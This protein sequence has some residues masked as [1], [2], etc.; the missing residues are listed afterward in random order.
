VEGEDFELN[1]E[2]RRVVELAR[3][4]RTP[5]DSDKRRV[6]AALAATLGGAALGVASS[7]AVASAAKSAGALVAMRALLAAALLTSAGVGTY[8]WTRAPRG[9]S[10]VAP[11]V[12]PPTAP[13]VVVEPLPPA[14]APP[15]EGDPLLAELTLLRQAQ[16]ALRDGDAKRAL[17]LAAR[18]AALY[19][20]SQMSVERGALRVFALCSLG[21]KSEARTLARE[22]IA[23]APSS[24]LRKSLE[25]SCGMR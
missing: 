19:P 3:A 6:R 12:A 7:T 25:E 16:R 14:A 24:P 9:P 10:V 13:S 11:A 23:E 5:G 1:G 17:E 2:E 8:F 22:L 18:H 20:R 15:A 21:R 4:A